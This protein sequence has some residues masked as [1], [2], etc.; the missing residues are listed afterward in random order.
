MESDKTKR[1]KEPT[2]AQPG[3]PLINWRA[4]HQTEFFRLE[5]APILRARLLSVIF[6][7]GALAWSADSANAAPTAPGGISLAVV[8]LADPAGEVPA[9]NNVSGSRV[10]NISIAFPAIV[11]KHGKNEVISIASQ[12]FTFSGTCRTSFT[13][14]TPIRGIPT[15][16]AQGASKLYTCNA[17][18]DVVYFFE[19]AALPDDPGAAT[20]TATVA[21]G[22]TAITKTVALTIE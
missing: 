12:D 4:T 16:I 10:P 7:L 14:T 19:T 8:G 15:I 9:V 1:R 20:L 18:G 13:L 21:F 5:R 11:L 17:G 3:E 2:F 6:A 22:S